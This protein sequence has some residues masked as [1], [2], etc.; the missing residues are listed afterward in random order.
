MKE[1][2]I[3]GLRVCNCVRMGRILGSE[4]PARIRWV[5]EARASVRAIWEPMPWGEGPVM[6]TG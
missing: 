3:E 5:G 2:R 1:V 4:R 6:R